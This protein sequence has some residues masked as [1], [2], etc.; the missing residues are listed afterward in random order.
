MDLFKSDLFR[1]F[2]IGFLLGAVLLVG[3]IW[4][5]SEDGISGKVIPKAEA[6]APL[7]DRTR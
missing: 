2:G 3:S 1:S 6:A 5:Q 7:P 4:A